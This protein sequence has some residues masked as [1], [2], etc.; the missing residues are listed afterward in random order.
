MPL[1]VGAGS[2]AIQYKGPFATDPAGDST[3]DLFFNTTQKSFKFNDSGTYK[4]VSLGA[5]G[6]QGNPA[7]GPQALYDAGQRVNG[8]Y[9]LNPDGGNGAP[10]YC[11]LDGGTTFASGTNSGYGWALAMKINH[12]FFYG[13]YLANRLDGHTNQVGPTLSNQNTYSGGSNGA[14]HY[15]PDGA[16]HVLFGFTNNNNN[17]LTDWT[18]TTVPGSGA[19]NTGLYRTSMSGVSNHISTTLVQ[20]N[21]SGGGNYDDW[22]FRPTTNSYYYPIGVSKGLNHN[23]TCDNTTSLLGVMN[24]SCSQATYNGIQAPNQ[25]S[26]TYVGNR[27]NLNSGNGAGGAYCVG[28]NS[29]AQY[30]KW[31]MWWR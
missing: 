31:M 3:G 26:E 30:A 2:S 5:L 18:H 12:P 13:Q 17:Q 23:S 27:K 28:E 6:D 22:H 29:D 20:S 11:W 1:H 7:S 9:Y 10:F 25:Y 16:T 14:G 8:Q 19:S 15:L 24:D 21:V 4:K